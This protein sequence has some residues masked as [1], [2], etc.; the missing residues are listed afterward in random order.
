MCKLHKKWRKTVTSLLV[1]ATMIVGSVPAVP[2]RAEGNVPVWARDTG[3]RV[4]TIFEAQADLPTS[5]DLRESFPN[6]VTPV[7]CQNP[8]ATCWAFGGIA[9]AETSIAADFKTPVN[10]SERHLTWFALHPVTDLDA[11]SSQAG[12]GMY[13]YGEDPETN[14]NGAYIASNPMLATSLFSTG[15]GPVLEED[16]PYRGKTGLTTYEYA[17]SHKDGWCAD[18]KKSLLKDYRSEEFLLELIKDNTEFTTIEDYIDSIYQKTVDGLKDGS[19][20]NSYSEKDDWRIDPV[21]EYGESNRNVFAG[22][23][24]RD[25]NLLP[26][27]TTKNE[28]GVVSLNDA[29]MQAMKQEL[30]SGRAVSVSICAD[31]SS[32]NQ[33]GVAKYTNTKTWAAYVYDGNSINHQVAIVGWDDDYATSN[34]NQGVDEKGLSKTPPA[35][36][37]WII[38]NSWGCKDGVET[39]KSEEYGD[40][41]LGKNDWGVDGSGYFYVSYY[42][43]SLSDPE[44]M[45]FGMDLAGEEF[46]THAYDYLPAYDKFYILEGKGTNVLSSANV[47]TAAYDEKITSV[48]TRT[49]ELNSRVTFAIYLLNDESKN[50]TDGTLVEKFSRTYGY[51]GFHRADLETPVKFK[52]GERFSVVSSVTYVNADGATVYETVANMAVGKERADL[53]LGTWNERSQYGKA[54]VNHGESYLYEQGVWK[55]WADKRDTENFKHS[56]NGCEVDNFSIKAYAVPWDGASFPDV[57]DA[58]PHSDEIRWLANSGIS[59]GYPDATF[60]PMYDVKRQD[61][62]AFLFRLAK[63]WGKVDDSW[64]PAEDQKAAFSDVNENTPHYREI[65]WLAA[66]G[67]STGYPNKTFRPM[68]SVTRQDMAAFLFRLAKLD[69][70]GGATDEWQPADAQKTAFPDVNENTPHAREIMWLAAS[71]VSTGYPDKTFR[72][73]HSVVRQDMAAFLYRLNGLGAVGEE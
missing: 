67:V 41:V 38:K 34:F 7:K 56:A 52:E 70:R 66:S 65:M 47:F 46:Y 10:L 50:P 28:Q 36:G 59:T 9:A 31:T 22:Y 72:P 48:S 4:G 62:A 55:D 24:I 53:L 45:S 54:V 16:F 12:E 1:V 18:A 43:T 20:V 19:V 11:P 25:G 71:G 49:D 51:A 17:L 33:Q 73:M 23:T 14:P 26:S 15:V 57:T 44:T 2:A 61:M 68:L 42:D 27:P 58:T 3:E 69:G 64:Q 8:Y 29:G 39:K 30:M 37:A 13:V 21:D 63:L 40:Q 5:F 35:A 6:N 60:R 32:P